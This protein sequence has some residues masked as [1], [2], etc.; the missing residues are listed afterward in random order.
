MLL[1]E[2]MNDV[3]EYSEAAEKGGDLF[4]S[5]WRKNELAVM[6]GETG[7][8][9]S[10]LATQ[11]AQAIACGSSTLPFLSS[12][13]PQKV[14]YLDLELTN[15]KF[16]ERYYQIPRRAGEIS[17]G[18]KFNKG[19]FRGRV[20]EDELDLPPDMNYRSYVM[21]SIWQAVITTKTKVLII[22]N[23]SFF[24][25][26]FVSP[27]HAQGL[28]KRLNQLKTE[29]GVSILLLAHTPKR[30]PDSPLTLNDVQGSKF[31]SY[32]T[33]S[34]FGVGIGKN[35]QIRYLKQIKSRYDRVRYDSSN[36][37]IYELEKKRIKPNSV[38]PPLAFWYLENG[39]ENELLSQN[40]YRR[41]VEKEMVKQL[42]S[43]GKTQRE[44]AVELNTSASTVNR[45]LSAENL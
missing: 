17:K 35:E 44:I 11:I 30:K 12:H 43:L 2:E 8:G 42:H 13:S 14:L 28:M 41:N 25:T 15:D 18:Y 21:R 31:L 34:I 29:L 33:D 5:L 7:S 40:R 1:I 4:G 19:L 32:F 27:G 24:D 16:A 45:I 26:T 37:L 3:Y 10:I 22:D 36:V 38:V 23:I 6:F 39:S 9:K 20:D